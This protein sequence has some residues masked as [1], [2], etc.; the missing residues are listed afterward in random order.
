MDDQMLREFRNFV[1]Y[2]EK[3]DRIADDQHRE[4]VRAIRDLTEVINNG[5]T[6]ISQTLQ[7]LGRSAR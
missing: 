2:R 3:R 7:D 5:V 6:V 1:S 4:T